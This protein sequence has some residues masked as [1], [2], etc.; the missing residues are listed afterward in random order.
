MY[1]ALI[2]LVVF[3]IASPGT[4]RADEIVRQVQEELRN[5]TL[6]RETSTVK[7][8]GIGWGSQ[9]LPKAQGLP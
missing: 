3:L 5:A 8:A 6:F 1:R 4:L 9:A 7:K 2:C